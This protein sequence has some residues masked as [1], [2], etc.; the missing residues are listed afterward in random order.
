MEDL[1][2]TLAGFDFT[3]ESEDVIH[4]GGNDMISLLV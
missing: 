1:L 2:K 4:V 3:T